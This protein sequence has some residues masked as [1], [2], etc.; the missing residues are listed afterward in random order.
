MP[1]HRLD[2][3]TPSFRRTVRQARSCWLAVG[4]VLAICVLANAVILVVAGLT[5]DGFQAMGI[6]V[7]GAL[8]TNGVILIVSVSFSGVVVRIAGRAGL[9][10]YLVAAVLLPAAACFADFFLAGVVHGLVN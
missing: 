4:I 6:A 5:L 3:A 7:F 2:Y 1:D 9:L 8:V 10:A